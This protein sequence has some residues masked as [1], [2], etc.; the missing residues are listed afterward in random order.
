[1]VL[2][3]NGPSGGC[4]QR[5]LCNTHGPAGAITGFVDQRIDAV[6]FV[7]T[8]NLDLRGQRFGPRCVDRSRLAMFGQLR[9]VAN[10]LYLATKQSIAP[11]RGA[12][13]HALN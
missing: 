4:R 1:M 11:E 12:P 7:A 3:V 6:E 2:L 9:S 8:Q 13:I 5:L 10:L